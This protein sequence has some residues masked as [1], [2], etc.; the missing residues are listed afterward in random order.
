MSKESAKK[1]L[2]DAAHKNE[3]REQ[4]SN[5]RNSQDFI[6]ISE[7]LGY[8]FTS[9]ELLEVVKEHSEGVTLRRQT[10]VWAWLR[11]VNWI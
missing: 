5:A 9:E 11:Q 7:E 6:A 3:I 8:D 4:F 10:G 1:F 2:A